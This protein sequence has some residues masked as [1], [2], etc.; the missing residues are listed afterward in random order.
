MTVAF[1]E[2]LT[3]VL[4]AANNGRR[5]G[6]LDLDDAGHSIQHADFAADG[7]LGPFQGDGVGVSLRVGQ[8]VHEIWS[9]RSHVTIMVTVRDGEWFTVGAADSSGLAML[10][11][12]NAWPIELRALGSKV[13]GWRR[14]FLAWARRGTR[15]DRVRVE[16][17]RALEWVKINKEK[18]QIPSGRFK[19]L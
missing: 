8:P 17:R 5:D 14:A 9:S 3:R 13:S 10:A 12:D 11:L 19:S 1:E 16:R 15:A 6:S 2:S 4:V 18:F 7:R